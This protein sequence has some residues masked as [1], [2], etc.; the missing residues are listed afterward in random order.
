LEDEMRS[1]PITGQALEHATIHDVEVDVSPGHGVWLDRSE[2][3]RIT[4][5]ARHQIER[6]WLG[7][8]IAWFRTQERPATVDQRVHPPDLPCPVCGETMV[9]THYREVGIDRCRRH[10]VWLDE[11]ELD[12]ILGRLGEEPEFLRGVSLR[13][14]DTAL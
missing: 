4:E 9:L 12:L 13:L 7:R 11:G 8:L 1:C 3:A 2:L 6:P 5:A 14:H 10:G